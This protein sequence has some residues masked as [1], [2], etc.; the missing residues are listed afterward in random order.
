ME[1]SHQ[2]GRL[3]VCGAV[4]LCCAGVPALIYGLAFGLSGGPVSTTRTFLA[5]LGKG[6]NH[7]AYALGSSAFRS[8][9]TPGML[10]MEAKKLGLNSYSSSSWP[11]V[12]VEADRATLEGTVTTKDGE[13]VPLVVVLVREKDGWRVLSVAARPEAE[14]GESEASDG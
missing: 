2:T 1:V 11:E 14:S 13:A 3:L 9:R 5:L 12:R 7:D 6:K 8:Q 10:G 4:V